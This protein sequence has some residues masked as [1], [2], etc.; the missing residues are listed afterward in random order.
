MFGFNQYVPL[1]SINF[2]MQVGRQVKFSME[3]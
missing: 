1:Y 2:C 3:W